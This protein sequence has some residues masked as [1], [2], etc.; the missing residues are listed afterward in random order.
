MPPPAVQGIA[1]P[2]SKEP[3]YSSVY[4]NAKYPD[5]LQAY[6]TPEV[7]T[8]FESFERAVRLY[9]KHDCLGHREYDRPTKTWGPYVWESYEEIHAR[10]ARLGSGLLNLYEQVAK[11]CPLARFMCMTDYVARWIEYSRGTT[12]CDDILAQPSRMGH[13]RSCMSSVFVCCCCS[14]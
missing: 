11:V 12:M 14:I 8:L 9:P 10:T 6:D 2:N 4:R 13:H 7:R 1:V 3:G 5:A